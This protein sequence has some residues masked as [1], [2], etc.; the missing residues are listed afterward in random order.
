MQP[1]TCKVKIRVHVMIRTRSYEPFEDRKIS[2]RGR[3]CDSVFHEQSY[4]CASLILNKMSMISEDGKETRDD[5][6]THK[7]SPMCIIRIDHC[8]VI[9]LTIRCRSNQSTTF[10]TPSIMLII[11]DRRLSLPLYFLL[12]QTMLPDRYKRRD[13]ILA[14]V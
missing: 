5:W 8:S 6:S 3:E 2:R 4:A 13:T 12:L 1:W 7:K 11:R 9:Q 10:P 14:V